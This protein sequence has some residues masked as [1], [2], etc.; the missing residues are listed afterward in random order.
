MSSTR[1]ISENALGI[2]KKRYFEPDETNV[3]QVFHRVADG[4]TEFE[5]IMQQGWFLPNSPTLMN[6]G[7]SNE[8]KATFSACVPAGE[9]VCLNNEIL[10]VEQVAEGAT[11]LTHTGKLGDVSEKYERE[12]I[13]KVVV[14]SPYFVPSL[15]LTPE[16]PVWARK[17]RFQ[18]NGRMTVEVEAPCWLPVAELTQGDMVFMPKTVGQSW[19][20][21][22]LAW[23]AGL[24]AA[25][26]YHPF[27][28]AT[29]FC[30][31]KLKDQAIAERLE[32]IVKRITSDL[33][34][35]TRKERD[36]RL[37]IYIGSKWFAE[38]IRKYVEGKVG[39]KRLT[40]EAADLKDSEVIESLIDGWQAG[41]GFASHSQGRGN[42]GATISKTLAWQLRSLS[43]RSDRPLSLVVRPARGHSK[44]AYLLVETTQKNI[45]KSEDNTG[46][47]VRLRKVTTEDYAGIVY[48]FEV[49]G[50]HSYTVGGVAVHNCF[51]FDVADSMLEGEDSII[52]TARK[53]AS[54]AKWGGGVGYYLGDLRGRLKPIRSVHRVACGVVNVIHH[55]NSIGTH[56]ITQGG[57][58]ELAQMGILPIDHDDIREFI[59]VKDKDPQAL[60]TFNISVSIHDEFMKK[61]VAGEKMEL[62]DEIIQSAWKTG[63][64]GLYFRDVVER[65]NPTPHLG[66]LTGTNPCLTADNWVLTTDGPSQVIDLV[67]VPFKPIVD[68]EIYG[69]GGFFKTGTK[70]VKKVT[71]S[72]GMSF[73]ATDN[74]R[75]LVVT[76]QTRKVQRTA[77][78]TVGELTSADRVVLHNQRNSVWTGRG[79]AQEGY[80]LGNMLGDGHIEKDGTANLEYWGDSQEEMRQHA[81][82]LLQSTVGA[83]VTG[84]SVGPKLRIGSKRLGDL[85]K[86]YG[87]MNGNKTVGPI[88]ER[89]SSV[90]HC[91]FLRGWFDADGSVQGSQTKGVSVRLASSVLPNLQAAQRMLAR[92]GVI[93]VIYENRQA[94]GLRSLPD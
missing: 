45:R 62:W 84:T 61:V 65:T 36:N 68:G 8:G 15:R 87:M 4:N 19:M 89:S 32:R 29:V 18:S 39:D 76:H 80:L 43:L 57:R 78:K 37:D 90:F 53:A 16:H 64:P 27:K 63:D 41:D 11:M 17:A 73:R 77:W 70:P 67:D 44:K 88:V 13:G 2:W 75:V 34:T 28:N 91:G 7:T 51:K 79:S 69:S 71:L 92:L 14:L 38:S 49:P 12:Y 52:E 6:A 81:A 22:D 26:G 72:N 59:H 82:E 54:V 5:H 42:I 58:R 56:L 1:V 60:R 55:Y 83:T 9:T 10:P 66:K 48:N 85:A 30:L 47:W 40:C 3:D 20:R 23:L 94:A 86:T 21:P 24:Y 25:D 33:T 93:S 50:D 74:H 31:N 46:Y 35:F